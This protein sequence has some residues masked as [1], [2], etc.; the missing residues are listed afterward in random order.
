M[1]IV[2]EIIAFLRSDVLNQL[3]R[4][5]VGYHNAIKWNLIVSSMLT[6]KEKSFLRKAAIK[7][8]KYQQN[9]YENGKTVLIVMLSA[10]LGLLR[11]D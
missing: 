2:S 10:Y 7:V 6:V 9:Y 3:N 4:I 1:L 8:S 5:T 11:F